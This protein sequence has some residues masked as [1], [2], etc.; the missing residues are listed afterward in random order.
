MMADGVV[1]RL[2]AAIRIYY[3]GKDKLSYRKSRIRALKAFGCNMWPIFPT[4]W[5]SDVLFKTK[6]RKALAT[7]SYF[8]VYGVDSYTDLKV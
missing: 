6:T 1:T 5:E 7:A 8:K 4:L 3:V 2:N